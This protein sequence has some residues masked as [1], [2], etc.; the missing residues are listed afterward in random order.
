MEF[1]THDLRF[2]VRALFRTRGFLLLAVGAIALGVGANTTIFS[3]LN[4]LVLKPLPFPEPDRLLYLDEQTPERGTVDWMSTSYP[5]FADWRAQSRSF[6][7]MAAFRDAAFDLSGGGEAERASGAVVSEDLFRVLGVTP[8]LGRGFAVGEGA[9]SAP[10]V[11]VLGHALWTRWYGGDRA[12]VGKTLRIDGT[13]HTIV[14]VMPVGFRFPEYA[15]LW[16]PLRADSAHRRRGERTLAA[17][18]RLAPGAEL[19]GAAGEIAIIN[20]RLAE[21]HPESN[22]GVTVAVRP[23]HEALRGETGHAALLFQGLTL[24]VMAIAWANV[25]NL[26]LARSVERRKEMAV[27]SA[28]GASRGRIVRQLVAEGAVLAG[29]GGAAGVLMGLAGRSLLVAAIPIQLPF[30]VDFSLDWRVL[31]FAAGLSLAGVVFFA[32]APALQLRRVELQEVLKAGGRGTTDAHAGRMQGT[33]VVVETAL[34]LVLLVGAGMLAKSLVALRAVDPGFRAEGVATARLALSLRRYPASA[35]QQALWDELIARVS[36][37]PGVE[38]A[39]AVGVLPLGGGGRGSE[40]AVE[41]RVAAAGEEAPFALSNPVSRGYFRVMRI[42]LRAG[43]AFD[44]SERADAVPV[45]VVNET[46]ARLWW[47]GESAVGKR[48]R[49]GRAAG[50]W[51]E[52]VGVVGDVKDTRVALPPWPTVYVPLAQAALPFGR[53][54]VRTRA[55]NPADVIPGVR[56]ELRRID[57]EL[58][59]DQAGTLHEVARRSMWLPRLYAWLAGVF[60]VIALGLSSLGI[61]GIL[62]YT[63][64]QRTQE[65]GIRAA[66]G[67]SPR[68]VTALFV[69]RGARLAG[70]AVVLGL[71]ASWVLTRL[72]RSLLYGVGGSDLVVFAAGPVVMFAVALT[73]AF[74]PARAATRVEPSVALRHD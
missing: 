35:Q 9:P 56:G 28:L 6:S 52:V 48:V 66:L 61:Y 62:S 57:P 71:P 14:G 72:L 55:G 23:L 25:A 47:P 29:L 58:P 42:P 65:I 13:E 26:L 16:V 31:V 49:L 33:L 73:A 74:I 68:A 30:W 7:A 21:A 15:E 12:A 8:L 3:V 44:G 36:A 46:M 1:L 64:R 41:G 38:G 24:V 63:V 32:L 70:M 67:A 37:L 2:A 53:L 45:V 22:D 11:V 20:W 54:V 50:P 18:G 39:A 19:E 4:P 40:V 17:V 60:A 27:R 51:R 5:D 43:R 59:V 34:V 69:A 10:A